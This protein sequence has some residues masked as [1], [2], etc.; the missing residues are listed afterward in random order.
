MFAQIYIRF[1]WKSIHIQQM[2]E[3]KKYT[4]EISGNCGLPYEH[5]NYLNHLKQTG[6]SP[7]VIYDIGSSLL[8]WTHEAEKIW[9]DATI[10]LFDAF[11]PVEF[12]YSSYKYHIGV[13]SNTNDKDVKFYYNLDA[14]GGGSYYREIGFENYTYFPP[15]QFVMRRTSTLDTIVHNRHL[16]Y[17][18]LIK[19]DVQGCE[20]DIIEGAQVCLQHANR[21]IV[22]MQNIEYNEGA[23]NVE[24]T[25]PYIQSLGWYCDAPLFCNNGPDGDYG[26][27]KNI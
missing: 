7:S 11:D 25:L 14:P 3:W 17:P 1:K 9:P 2:E 26:F 5:I 13:L 8:H 4:K 6:Y 23:P 18:D 20:K 16:P 19:M 10:I 21:L 27:V 24:I 22:E 12:L 15:D